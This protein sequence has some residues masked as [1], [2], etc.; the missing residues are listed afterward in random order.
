MTTTDKIVS[1]FPIGADCRS[2]YNQ[3]I[4]YTDKIIY[5]CN[6][7]WDILDDVN[8]LPYD[9]TVMKYLTDTV[10][11]KSAFIESIDKVDAKE[12]VEVKNNDSRRD[13]WSK[14]GKTKGIE[15]ANKSEKRKELEPI[16][17]TIIDR[18]IKGETIYSLAKNY[19][20]G[21]DILRDMISKG[22]HDRNIREETLS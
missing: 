8:D 2:S 7:L 15:S 10:I 13:G 22:K 19:G 3:R 20:I 14:G 12:C 6:D 16:I 21:K 11:A 17:D 5:D 4:P 1:V 9:D 18:N